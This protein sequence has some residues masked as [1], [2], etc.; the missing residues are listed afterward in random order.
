MGSP[1][2]AALAI[3]TPLTGRHPS[4]CTAS[5]VTQLTVDTD[6]DRV[7]GGRAGKGTTNEAAR[8][9]ARP[10]RPTP[11]PSTLTDLDRD[12][13]WAAAVD[14]RHGRP[15]G[16]KLWHDVNNDNAWDGGDA[17]LSTSKT[18][19][20]RQRVTFDTIGF[21]ITSGARLRSCWSRL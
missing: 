17:Q 11:T 3:A 9:G 19:C 8:H 5:A 12:A 15:S 14:A 10:E 1:D 16:I 7:V 20:G 18:F 2:S 13:H 6:R 4:P 21:T